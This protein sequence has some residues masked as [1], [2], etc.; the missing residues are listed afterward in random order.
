MFFAKFQ[1]PALFIC[2]ESTEGDRARF[3]VG[4][5]K[6]GPIQVH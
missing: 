2:L 6:K 1:P 3:R 4:I 5:L